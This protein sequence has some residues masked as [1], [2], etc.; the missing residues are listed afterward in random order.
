M[1]FMAKCVKLPFQKKQKGLTNDA[2]HICLVIGIDTEDHRLASLHRI[3]P[4]FNGMREIDAD[5]QSIKN[6]HAESGTGAKKGFRRC[7]TCESLLPLFNCEQK[8]LCSSYSPT[9]LLV[10]MVQII[11]I[12]LTLRILVGFSPRRMARLFF[13]PAL[14][15]SGKPS[16]LGSPHLT[17]F[18]R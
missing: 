14:F 16:P 12:L 6:V 4:L 2:C 1:G 8:A 13:L 5:C 15:H 7:Q 18:V 3:T 10:S 11:L 9:A 17:N